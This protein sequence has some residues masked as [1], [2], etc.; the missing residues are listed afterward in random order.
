MTLLHV[1]E[2]AEAAGSREGECVAGV[3]ASESLM[4]DL[5]ETPLEGEGASTSLCCRAFQGYCS[6]KASFSLLGCLPELKIALESC[7]FP[8]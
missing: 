4:G 8:P 2:C 7:F 1:T 3:W 5:Q 6:H